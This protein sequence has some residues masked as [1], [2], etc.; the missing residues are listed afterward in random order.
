MK[1]LNLLLKFYSYQKVT[2]LIFIL[3]ILSMFE[4]IGFAVLM[5]LISLVLNFNNEFIQGSQNIIIKNVVNL[6]NIEDKF[7]FLNIYLLFVLTYYFTKFIFTLGTIKYY[8][9]FLYNFK[10]KTIATILTNF[11]SRSYLFHLNS[12]SSDLVRF[13]SDEVRY[14]FDSVISPMLLVITEIFIIS[15]LII[16]SFVISPK[17]FC[18]IL[19]FSIICYLIIKIIKKKLPELGKQRLEKDLLRHN[20]LQQTFNA[21]KE[22]KIFKKENVYLKEVKD[23][24]EN[25]SNVEK[26][27]FFLES[28]PRYLIEFLI[29]LQ[30]CILFY[31]FFNFFNISINEDYLPIFGIYLLILFRILPSFTRISRSL[32]VINYAQK[33]EN[34]IYDFIFNSKNENDNHVKSFDF[35][36]SIEIKNI[37]FKYSEDSTEIEFNKSF[38]IKKGSFNCIVG[39]SGVGKTTLL[40]LISGL[41][42]PS[43]SEFLIDGIKIINSP[44]KLNQKISFVHQN[45]FLFND[46]IKKNICFLEKESEIDTLK[47]NRIIEICELK[48]LLES[49]PD[50]LNTIIGERGA[51]LSGGERQRLSIA[52]ALYLDAEIVLLDEATNALDKETEDRILNNLKS[53]YHGKKTFI[54]VL[55]KILDKSIFDKIIDV[56]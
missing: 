18:V 15:G 46:T 24:T 55:H 7:H 53:E 16:F 44:L 10:N 22:I 29:V 27:F 51:K 17:L 26:K 3:I 35:N 5:P 14:Y 49:L 21:I 40:D 39:K 34:R 33:L 4:T 45:F 50:K 11:L 28:L 38:I 13:T 12:I 54:M 8:S 48:N 37:A 19:F 6:F 52:R 36:K 30:F 9:N 2:F 42:T 25:L 41:L 23:V 32:N 47:L 56:G 20:I 43:K 31:V 1:V